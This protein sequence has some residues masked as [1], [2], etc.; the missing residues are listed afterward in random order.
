M[1]CGSVTDICQVGVPP[2]A[3][4]KK[5]KARKGKMVKNILKR[6]EE[7]NTYLTNI[8]RHRWRKR[9]SKKI[10]EVGA[11]SQ[12]CGFHQLLLSQLMKA[13]VLAEAS[14]FIHFHRALSPPVMS[15]DVSQVSLSSL[16]FKIFF[17]LSPLITFFFAYAQCCVQWNME[18][19]S[20]KY[21]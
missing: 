18:R 4:I 16:L 1:L 3:P 5:R 14:Y 19:E 11:F 10:D 6:R 20:T 7:S 2:F 8:C 12:H 15:T 17:I 13:T 9:S 21:G